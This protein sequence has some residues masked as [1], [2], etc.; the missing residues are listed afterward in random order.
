MS[1]HERELIPLTLA[2]SVSVSGHTLIVSVS[3]R[4]PL[5]LI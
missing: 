5:T 3:E 2:M 1:A 4:C